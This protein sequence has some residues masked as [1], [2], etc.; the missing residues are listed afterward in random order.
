MITLYLFVA[1]IYIYCQ[2]D[3]KYF[4]NNSQRVNHLFQSDKLIIKAGKLI[5]I[6]KKSLFPL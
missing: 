1:K 5:W 3:A 6:C 4:I 2:T